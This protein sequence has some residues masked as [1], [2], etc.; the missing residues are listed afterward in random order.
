[1]KSSAGGL[2]RP[3]NE[4]YADIV[5]RERDAIRLREEPQQT[6]ASK[7]AIVIRIVL[8]L[9]AVAVCVLLLVF[10]LK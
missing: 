9:I 5:Q 7:R 1:M 4:A 6:G 3:K 2:Q 10:F 8:G